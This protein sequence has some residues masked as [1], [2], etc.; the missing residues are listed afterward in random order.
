LSVT[1]PYNADFDG[2]EM[3][4]FV[5][6]SYETLA[7][8]K[9]LMAV[10]SQIVSPQANRPIMG[11]VQDCLLGIMLLTRRDCFI[12]KAQAMNLM[13]WIRDG[14]VLPPPAILKPRPLWTGKQLLSLVIPNVNLVR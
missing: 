3:N 7:E 9:E 4:M 6:Q 2:D 13:M 12:D 1:Q 11:I 8:V 5:P 10:P 14:K